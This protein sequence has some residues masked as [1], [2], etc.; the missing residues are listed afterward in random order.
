MLVFLYSHIRYRVRLWDD[1]T[2]SYIEDDET[3]LVVVDTSCI[4]REKNGIHSI[5]QDK[6]KMFLKYHCEQVDGIWRV[7]VLPIVI[8]FHISFCLL[9]Y[10]SL[11]RIVPDLE[12]LYDF[13]YVPNSLNNMRLAKFTWSDCKSVGASFAVEVLLTFMIYHHNISIR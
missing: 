13:Y 11:F 7:K 4:R 9:L 6:S 5:N 12:D 1:E 2:N 10:A 8:K 3:G